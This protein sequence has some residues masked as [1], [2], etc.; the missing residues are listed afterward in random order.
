MAIWEH[1]QR[2]GELTGILVPLLVR[3]PIVAVPHHDAPILAPIW[4]VSPR[5]HQHLPGMRYNGALPHLRLAL[6]VSAPNGDDL[7]GVQGN[8]PV[9]VHL[10]V[11][12][13]GFLAGRKKATLVI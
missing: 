1:A 5:R 9:R 6:V 12:V 2:T 8:T 11:S 13:P 10:H 7:V 3:G 4:L